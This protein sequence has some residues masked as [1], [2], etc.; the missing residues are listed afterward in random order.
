MYGQAYSGHEQDLKQAT[1]LAR[2]MVTHWGMSDRLGPMA[3]RMG[4][5]HVFL[6]K[7]IQEARDF[8]DTTAAIIDQEVQKIL[9]EADDRA[10]HLLETNRDKLERLVAALVEKEELYR[11]EINEIFGGERPSRHS[12]ELQRE[13]LLPSNGEPALAAPA[14]V[15]AVKDN[16]KPT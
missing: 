3:F 11:D 4:E 13:G 16:H 10:R 9:R 8:S 2:Y 14:S 5:E 1:R 15:T 7:E 6:G 12:E